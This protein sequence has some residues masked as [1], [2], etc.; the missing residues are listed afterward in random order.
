MQGQILLS[1]EFATAQ[2]ELDIRKL[3]SGVYYLL[4]RVGN[5]KKMTRFIKK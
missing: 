3:N 2:T 4:I 1:K 5:D